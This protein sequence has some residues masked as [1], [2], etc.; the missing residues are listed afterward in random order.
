MDGKEIWIE[1]AFEAVRNGTTLV[2]WFR[3]VGFN[4]STM[5]YWL[6]HEPDLMKRYEAARDLGFDAIA[7]NSRLVSRGVEGFSSGCPKRDRLIVETDLKLLG[8][9]SQRY[10]D[11]SRVEATVT[12]L[13]AV[14]PAA[15][16]DS[17]E[18][19][20]AYQD[21]IRMVPPAAQPETLQ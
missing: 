17:Q 11:R 12:N 14:L 8:K 4:P 6:A 9:W 1:L 15:D 10:A 7:S 19:A 13:T 2:E 21:F 5:Y 3:E 18:A 16:M 20:R